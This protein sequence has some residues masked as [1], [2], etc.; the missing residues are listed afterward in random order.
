MSDVLI[1]QENRTLIL[2]L[3]RPEKY[4]AFTAAMYASLADALRE[5]N[6][7]DSIRAVVITGG[8]SCFCSGND[9]KDFLDAPPQTLNAPVFRFMDAVLGLH[10]PL[11]AAVC[12][13][14]IGIGTTL[15]LH[16]DQVCITHGSKLALPFV[17]LGLCPE[18]GSTLKLP[19]LLGP[20]LAS[21]LLLCGDAFSGQDA[22][23]WKIASHGFERPDECIAHALALAARFADSDQEAM[24]ETRKLLKATTPV[25]SNVIRAENQAFIALL[26]RAETREAIGA[27]IKA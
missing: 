2:R 4:N 3:D 10:K 1:Q 24:R 12:G 13:V 14:A 18:F 22:V 27:L 8:E 15:L 17:K 21:R 5:A 9:L 6:T 11:I 20:V 26:S 7:D 23:A 25:L 16:C 19:A